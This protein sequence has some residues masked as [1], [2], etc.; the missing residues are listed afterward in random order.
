MSELRLQDL[1]PCV[2]ASTE[3]S[4]SALMHEVMQPG[5]TG[6][7]PGQARPSMEKQPNLVLSWE[8]TERTHCGQG[9]SPATHWVH[10]Q[11][12]TTLRVLIM[13]GSVTRFGAQEVMPGLAGAAVVFL[14]HPLQIGSLEP[15]VHFDKVQR[16]LKNHKAMA[17]FPK[18]PRKSGP[19]WRFLP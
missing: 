15:F 5:D 1:E 3:G 16:L 18:I 14:M 8:I 19:L 13:Q 10:Q 7:H 4:H 9:L 2:M 17:G 12:L 6:L 11:E